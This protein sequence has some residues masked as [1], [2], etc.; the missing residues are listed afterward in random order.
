MD[1]FSSLISCTVGGPI[2]GQTVGHTPFRPFVFKFLQLLPRF[3][4]FSLVI[5]LIMNRTHPQNRFSIKIKYVRQNGDVYFQD[6]KTVVQNGIIARSQP[7]RNYPPLCK[8]SMFRASNLPFEKICPDRF[9]SSSAYRDITLL[10]YTPE[11][12]F[13]WHV[14]LEPSEVEG[15]A[16]IP[17]RKPR[18]VR[19]RISSGKERSQKRI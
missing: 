9:N 17:F 4:H 13:L 2:S 18:M 15:V 3:V 10:L 1:I 7:P 11:N 5:T 19:Y 8:T 6:G 12:G 14:I 16:L